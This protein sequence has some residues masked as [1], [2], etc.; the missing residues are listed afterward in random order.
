VKEKL[1]VLIT[2]PI[3]YFQPILEELSSNSKITTKVFFGCTA[4]LNEYYDEEFKRLISW[5]SSPTSGFESQF[6][7]N[8]S[9]IG[10][11]SGIRGVWEGIRAAQAIMNWDANKVLIFA[12]TP[13]FITAATIWLKVFGQKSLILRADA[14]DGAFKRNSFKKTGRNILLPIYYLSFDL[15]IAIGSESEEHYKR[16]GIPEKR[17]R[18]ALFSSNVY[19]FENRIQR[20]KQEWSAPLEVKD[21][22]Q[23]ISYIGKL[24]RRKGV[25]TLLTAIRD[26]SQEEVGKIKL[27]IVGSGELN[28]IIQKQLREVRDLDYK[29]LGFVNQQEIVEHY[30]KSDTVVVPSIEGETWGLVV[31]EAIQ[32]GCRVIATDKVGASRD[33]LHVYPHEV[34]ESNDAI[35]L[36]EAINREFLKDRYWADDPNRYKQIPKPS[37]LSNTVIQWLLKSD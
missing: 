25:L 18:K 8:G 20:L 7:T 26:M 21:R 4:G 5:N 12:Y 10:K 17:R 36:R 22:K 32:C 37:D 28:D 30:A 19:F 24:S 9:N 29:I 14:T 11:L 31:N 1:G 13:T 16:K 2:H 23:T 6:I 3:Q 15:L 35:A 33:L 27:L 34:I